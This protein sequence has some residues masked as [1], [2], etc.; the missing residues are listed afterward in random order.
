MEPTILSQVEC[1]RGLEESRV[2]PAGREFLAVWTLV[3]AGATYALLWI[4]QCL[5]PILTNTLLSCLH[6]QPRPS[7]NTGVKY[8]DV[9]GPALPLL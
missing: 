9:E 7:E 6:F 8:L 3:W 1:S 2:K 5:A 4:H